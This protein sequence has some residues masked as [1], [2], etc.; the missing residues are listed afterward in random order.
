VNLN[1][2]AGEQFFTIPAPGAAALLGF[3]GLAALRRRR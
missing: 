3:A 1:D 2:F